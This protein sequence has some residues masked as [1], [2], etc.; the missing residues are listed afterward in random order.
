MTK[1]FD[2]PL[3]T[4]IEEEIEIPTITPVLNI[5]EKRVEFVKGTTKALQKTFYSDS[6]K[7]MVVCNDHEYIC[8]DKGKYRFQCKNCDWTKIA[9]PV[10]YKF[11]EKTGKLTYRK[12]GI[13][14]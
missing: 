6:P 2:K 14:V 4:F 8:V 11:N 9:Y 13:Q 1:P 3:N 7:K 5:K 10:T 12:T